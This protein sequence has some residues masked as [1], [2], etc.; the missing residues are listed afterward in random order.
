MVLVVPR[1][2]PT[3]VEVKFAVVYF[4]FNGILEL[5]R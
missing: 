4:L 2:F 3:G 5:E 1:F